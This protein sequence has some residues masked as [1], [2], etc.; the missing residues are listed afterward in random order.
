MKNFC[1]EWIVEWCHSHGWT[2]PFAERRNSYW[3]F[4]PNGVMPEPI[5]ARALREI[6]QAKGMTADER[7]WS[8]SAVAVALLAVGLSYCLYSPLPLV[9]AFA[10]AAVTV[11][12]LE[13]EYP[14]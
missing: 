13:V 14:Y 4:P 1:D 10:Y 8:T 3:A 9:L 2:E 7:F 11:A 12:R 5:P 6:K